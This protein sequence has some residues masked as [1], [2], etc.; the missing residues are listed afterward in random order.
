MLKR[1]HAKPEVRKRMRAHK[2]AAYAISSERDKAYV[3]RWRAANPDRV[4]DMNRRQR[5][6]RAGVLVV[7]SSTAN[8]YSAILRRD[9][10]S[11][12]GERGALDVDH[13]A[14]VSAGGTGDWENLTGACRPCNRSKKAR[15][16]LQFLLARGS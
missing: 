15:P 11:Y 14:P 16:L 2:R 12:C 6:R 3:A 8:E 4:A 13:I 7:D 9:P 5:E 1:Y 10:C